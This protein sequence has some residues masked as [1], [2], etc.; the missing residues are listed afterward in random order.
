VQVQAR[1]QAIGQVGQLQRCQLLLQ[2]GD[3][4]QQLTDIRLQ[5]AGVCL[6]A[7]T[8]PWAAAIE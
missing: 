5:A 2:L 4:W 6:Q 8:A 3:Q 1:L 7:G